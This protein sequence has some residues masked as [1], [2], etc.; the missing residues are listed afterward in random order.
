MEEV[1]GNRALGLR[2]G[3]GIPR[4]TWLWTGCYVLAYISWQAFRWLPLSNAQ[5]ADPWFLPIGVAGIVAAWRA[6]RRAG[7]DPLRWAW[8]I[9]ALA[10]GSYFLGVVVEAA[11]QLAEGRVP[12][13]SLADACFL[14]FYPL[15][16][17]GLLRFP[18]GRSVRSD[19]LTFALDLALVAIG[20]GAVAWYFVL[21]TAVTHDGH[22]VFQDAVTVCYPL[23]DGLLVIGLVSRVLR[24]TAVEARNALM[25][26]WGGIACFVAA[27]LLWEYLRARGRYH[28]GGPVDLIWMFS[29]AL[30][31]LAASA[32]RPLPRRGEEPSPSGGR[33]GW[34]PYTAVALGLSVLLASSLGESFYRH[35]A[36][37]IVVI[38]LAA[39]LSVRQLVTRRWQRDAERRLE[40]LNALSRHGL[41]G[42]DLQALYEEAVKAVAADLDVEYCAIY[43]T[44]PEQRALHMVA[45]VGWSQ[46]SAEGRVLAVSA[47]THAGHAVLGDRPVVIGDLRE[48]PRF[49][50][51][52]GVLR[53]AGILSGAST[54]IRRRDGHYGALSVHSR[55]PRRYAAEEVSFLESVSGVLGAAADRAAAED[56]IRQHAMYD[57][58]TGLPNRLLFDDRLSRALAAA[59]RHRRTVALLFVDLDNFKSIN[60]SLGH[61]RGDEVLRAVADRLAAQTRPEDTLARLGGDEFA[62]LLAQIA[63]PGDAARVARRMLDELE[64]PLEGGDGRPL[65][66]AA[67]IGIAI[68]EPGGAA[69]AEVLERNADL[70]MYAAKGAG[71]AQVR[72]FE[73]SMHEDALR[74]LELTADLRTALERGEFTVNYQPVVA[75]VDERVTG[76][77]ALVRWNHPVHGLLAPGAF[78]SLAEDSGLIGAIGGFVLRE[79]TGQLSRWR[80][81]G[82]VDEA[83]SV[84]VNVSAAQLGEPGFVAEVVAALTRAGLPAANLIIEITESVL[85]RGDGV[86]ARLRA[87]HDLGVRLAVDDFG[88]GYSSLGYLHGFPFDILKIDRSFIAHLGGARGSDQLV[89]GIVSLAQCLALATVAEGVEHAA[90]A[91]ALRAMGVARCQG[92]LF[93]R[94]DSVAGIEVWLRPGA[95]LDGEPVAGAIDAAVASG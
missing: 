74:A 52:A 79:A 20:L 2:D 28:A 63:S 9:V 11:Y 92:Y 32:Q 65:V 4:A 45:A 67:S 57:A 41:A 13:V 94:P 42:D 71:R 50:A 66:V 30:L 24:S 37:V 35:V 81:E 58:L 29:V 49:A 70:A 23:G 51:G 78:V 87:L 56:R 3:L 5:A 72:F 91:R 26:L 75:L 46:A 77:E 18:V 83:F 19:R 64:A 21:A 85:V 36:L 93:S 31:V 89:R 73:P 22:G 68:A 40:T 90:Q 61:G 25:L 1:A 16:F 17:V 95:T 76:L 15:S 59:R 84:G 10:W 53:D 43:R 39:L 8:R 80:A 86:L 88:T 62:V 48:D 38:V 47:D 7:S 55:R 12:Y 82:R 54:P 60:D 69:S 6:S 33:A 34:L 44:E 14:A 27:D